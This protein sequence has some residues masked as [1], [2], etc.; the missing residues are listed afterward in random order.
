[1]A[2]NPNALAAGEAADQLVADLSRSFPEGMDY[3]ISYDTTRY[4]STAVQQV[5]ISL[6]DGQVQEVGLFEPTPEA[7]AGFVGVRLEAGP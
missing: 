3:V 6:L 7:P 4:V 2:T 1:M 5:V